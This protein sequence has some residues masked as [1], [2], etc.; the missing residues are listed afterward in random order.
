MNANKLCQ[1]LYAEMLIICC[2]DAK[3]LHHYIEFLKEA[4]DN[5]QKVMETYELAGRMFPKDMSMMK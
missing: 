4:D 1:H 3:H 5:E 2:K